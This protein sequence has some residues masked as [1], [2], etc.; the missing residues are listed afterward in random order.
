M[1]V[2]I[3]QE[4]SGAAEGSRSGNSQDGEAP[5]SA[6]GTRAGPSL[7][8]PPQDPRGPQHSNME[9]SLYSSVENKS[10]TTF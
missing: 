8:R 4:G 3:G 5:E 9:Q 6:E 10:K 7:A 1:C 2:C